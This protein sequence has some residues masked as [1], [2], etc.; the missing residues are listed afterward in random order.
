MHRRARRWSRPGPPAR[1][2]EPGSRGS[3]P[4]PRPRRRCPRGRRAHRAARLPPLV[5]VPPLAR[6]TS[7]ATHAPGAG[8]RRAGPAPRRRR[9]PTRFPGP[10]SARRSACHE[11]EA[12]STM[13]ASRRS[14]PSGTGTSRAERCAELSAMPPSAPMPERALPVGRTQVVGAP[15]ALLALHAAV[16]RLHHHRRAVAAHPGAARGPRCVV[17]PKRRCQAPRSRRRGRGAHGVG[18]GGH[19]RARAGAPSTAPPWRLVEVHG[20]R[21]ASAG[22][23]APVTSLHQ[24]APSRVTDAAQAA[25]GSSPRRPML[26]STVARQQVSPDDEEE[27]EQLG[28]PRTRRRGG[29]TFRRRLRPSIEHLVHGRSESAGPGRLHTAAPGPRRHGWICASVRPASLAIRACW[30]HS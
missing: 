17:P 29:A 7:S 16:D 1:H 19:V 8:D 27:L 2:S 30:F 15:P 9:Q 13:L 10:V 18:D 22:L 28:R 5:R 11:T 4:P 25:A 6:A 20:P 23:D 3:P 24:P 26:L 14:R 21:I 12:G